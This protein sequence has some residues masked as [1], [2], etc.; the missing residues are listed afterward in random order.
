[1]D[2]MELSNTLIYD[3]KLTCGSREVEE[4]RLVLPR[5]GEK[6]VEGW[7]GEVLKER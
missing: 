7:M 3:G 2:I 5:R 4:Q 1:M 6:E